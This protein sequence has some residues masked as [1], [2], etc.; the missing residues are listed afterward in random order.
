MECGKLQLQVEISLSSCRF[1]YRKNLSTLQFTQL[2]K[3]GLRFKYGIRTLHI[4]AERF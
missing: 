2:Y 4:M 1:E 3:Q